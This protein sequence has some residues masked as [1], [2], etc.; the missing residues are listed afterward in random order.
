MGPGRLG[1]VQHFSAVKSPLKKKGGGER[2][3]EPDAAVEQ[4]DR[5]E[6]GIAGQGGVRD[7]DRDGP[8]G[9]EIE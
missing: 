7:L 2:F 9:Q 1:G 4:P 3:G 6:P 5:Q 8:R